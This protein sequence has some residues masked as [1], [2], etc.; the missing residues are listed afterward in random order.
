MRTAQSDLPAWTI[1]LAITSFLAP[2]ITTVARA[3]V[4]CSCGVAHDGPCVHGFLT[5]ANGDAYESATD[6]EAAA[7]ES[8][9]ET[10]GFSEFQTVRRWSSTASSS[11][12]LRNG[13]PTTLTWGFINDGTS[14]TGPEGTSPSDLIA[15]FDSLYGAGTTGD[16]QD[17]PWF[18][19]F[20]ES[21]DR[22]S[23]ISGVTYV[24]E[25]NDGGA[26]LNAT[27]TPTGQLGVYA[28]I[29][30]GGHSID[31]NTGANTLAYNYF[32]NHSDMVIDTDNADF[33]GNTFGDSLR[34]RNTIMHEAGHGLGLHHL[35]SSDSQQLMEP[36]ISLNFV[37]P[38]ID[39]ILGV[40]RNYGDA[41]EKNGGN[42]TIAT[43]TEAGSLGLFDDWAIGTDADF[44]SAATIIS[45]DQ[46]DF[47]SVDDSSDSDFFLFTASADGLVDFRLKPVGPTYREGAQDGSQS[48]LSVSEQS[49]LLLTVYDETGAVITSVVADAAGDI[50]S[51]S[52]LSA[53]AGD[54]FYVEAS[55]LDSR[56]QLYRL[57]AALNPAPRSSTLIELANFGVDGGKVL[58][59]EVDGIGL[60]VRAEG[61]T[62]AT[63]A[64]ATDSIGIS[65]P[66][67]AMVVADDL[68]NGDYAT[69]ES[70]QITF[71][72]DV[73][74]DNLQ[75]EGLDI[76]GDESVIL[77]VLSGDNPFT[78]LTGYD[79]P[80]TLGTS[81][82]TFSSP[83]W[84]SEFI[85]F[86]FGVNGM[87]PLRIKAGTVLSLSSSGAI[88]G[89]IGLVS[90]SAS[91]TPE[92]ASISLI[93]AAAAGL[94][95]RR[96][97]G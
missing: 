47:I 90:I 45:L 63:L 34:L 72:D 96:R 89:G 57:D 67:D 82:L 76:G 22:W 1:A 35:D 78:S 39:D 53:E 50:L 38:Q 77:S 74:L 18:H 95:F 8:G 81:S 64:N 84:Q 27:T 94:G 3:A 62:P 44:T 5:Q 79:G 7:N 4:M 28:D 65:S 30:I 9:D 40:Q 12:F 32:P 20:A 48:P 46:V 21:F 87:A 16:L 97:A 75:L 31:G 51:L 68:I 66:G 24:Y 19:F 49:R 56:A 69:P 59:T 17:A 14:I 15:T 13:D 33:F 61:E 43:A 93:L 41:W 83:N 86:A 70:L 80:Y 25:P 11:G 2:V 52:D 58:A 6:G 55:G 73:R 42:D 29:R 37:G 36:S 85:N 92:P 23:Q 60:S 91:L 10:P 71:L 26:S 88:D 54:E